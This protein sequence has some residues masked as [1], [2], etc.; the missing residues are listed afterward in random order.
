MTKKTKRSRKSKR[1]TPANKPVVLANNVDP[2]PRKKR[3]QRGAKAGG[4]RGLKP[5]HVHAVCQV[6]DPFCP[7]ARNSKWPDGTQ[8]NT[9][10]EQLRGNTTLGADGTGK[11]CGAFAASAPYGY[12]GSVLAGDVATFSAAYTIYK[13]SSLLNTYGSNYR[14]VSFGLIFRCVASATTAGGIITL[15]TMSAPP[16]STTFTIGQELFSD[17]I[18]KAIQPGMELSWMAQPIGSGARDFIAQST[19][20]AVGSDWTSCI[21][22]I[23]GSPPGAVINVEWF[24]NVEFQPLSTARALTAIA[25]PNPPKS[26]VAEQATSSIH[27]KTGSFIEGGIKQ[28]EETVA[29]YAGEALNSFLDDPLESLAG[30]FAML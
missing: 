20:I 28:V 26:T 13:A 25:K 9:L 7:A 23:S 5:H 10:T 6:T 8:G 21:V 22:E 30:L 2:R 4:K 14:I 18:V 12:I 11:H 17:V 19:T 1:S 3:S 16:V 15:G 24:M 27:S 29:K